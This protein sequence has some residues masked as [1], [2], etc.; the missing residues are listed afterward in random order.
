MVGDS[1]ID[2]GDNHHQHAHTS[3]TLESKDDD[4]VARLKKVADELEAAQKAAKKTVSKLKKAQRAHAKALRVV[5]SADRRK[6]KRR[7][8]EHRAKK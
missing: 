2:P 7:G 4:S 8:K 1:A 5:D 3:L 6:G